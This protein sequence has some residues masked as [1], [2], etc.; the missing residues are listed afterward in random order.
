MTE[1]S[2]ELRKSMTEAER[3]LW[4]GLRKRQLDGVRFRRQHPIGPH[5]AD[6]ICLERTLVVEVDGGQHAEPEQRAHDVFTNLDGVLATIF[7]ALQDRPVRA[8]GSTPT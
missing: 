6:F 5:V 1:R 8:R 3:L 4:W 7:G 2:R